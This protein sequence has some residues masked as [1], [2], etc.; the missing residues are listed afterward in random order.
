MADLTAVI[1]GDAHVPT[2]RDVLLFDRVAVIGVKQ[3]LTRVDEGTRRTLVTLVEHG[4]IIDVS[5]PKP[6]ATIDEIPGLTRAEVA[7]ALADS[8]VSTILSTVLERPAY[9]SLATDSFLIASVIEALE[10]G[11]SVDPAIVADAATR[12]VKAVFDS[13]RP[14]EDAFRSADALA[15]D[16]LARYVSQHLRAVHDRDFFPLTDRGLPWDMSASATPV[17]EVAQIVLTNIPEPAESTPW[18]A[19]L[20]FRADPD[21]QSA[22]R[23]FMRWATK[24]ASSNRPSREI[25]D[26]MESLMDDYREYMRI[27][28]IKSAH[29]RLETVLVLTAEMV[30][31]L[32]K[33]QLSRAVKALFDIRR[34]DAELLEAERTAP[35]R[36]LAFVI[37]VE[38]NFGG[39]V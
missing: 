17:S 23:R 32:L 10:I 26:E 1:H 11:P 8:A 37:K 22:R 18:D 30:E 20:E 16:R 12:R 38:E 3:L 7:S 35:G 6:G 14:L 31:S 13:G 2:K 25:K 4:V 15:S 29:G 9:R 19:L 28:S 36:E 24:M 27:H 39:G 5:F 34:F 33:L 21:V